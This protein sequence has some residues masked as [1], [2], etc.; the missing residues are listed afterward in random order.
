MIK[1]TTGRLRR[2]GVLA[3]VP[4]L[5]A[6]TLSACG[7]GD[8][9]SGDDQSFTFIYPTATNTESPY[10]TLAKKY[11]SET[12]TKIETRKLPN[13]S[14]GTALR[15]QLQGGNAPDLMVVAPGR[16]QEYAVLALAD[17]KLLAPLNDA[18]TSTVPDGAK[19]LFTLDGKTYAQPTDLVPVGMVWNKGAAEKGG[20]AFPQDSDAML[21]ACKTL[22]SSGK[23]FLALAGTAP[24]NLGL[25]AMS[26]SAS[27]VYAQTPD[28]NKQRADNKVTFAN[29]QGWQDT[30]RTIEQMNQAGCFQKG[31]AGGGFDAI[32]QGV[33]R[34]TSLGAFVPGGAAQELM[35]ATPGLTLEIRAFPAAAGAKPFLLASA[36]YA[37]AINAKAKAG[38]KTAAQKFLNWLAEPDNA[39]EFTKIEGQVPISGVDK[40]EL[41]PQ[42]APVKDLLAKGDY[43]PLPN[44]E[45]P[46]PAVYDAL[47]KGLQGM[48]AGKGNAQSVLEATDKAWDGR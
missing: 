46:N 47:S 40:A 24:P 12:G 32:T 36:N 23:S 10:E 14:Y 34:G 5:G 7:G 38:Q 27:R 17:A 29:S 44:L 8:S 35:N 41:A 30:V 18:S 4:L 25:M 16:G 1:H 28:W 26:I 45:W 2:F 13:D 6:L 11:S 19:G 43:A 48:I 22:A 33:T 15:T 37:L 21:A 3:A 20:T 39:A 31:A 42:Y 9:G